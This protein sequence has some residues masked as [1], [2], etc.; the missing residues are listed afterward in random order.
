MRLLWQSIRHIPELCQR[1][2][3]SC[4]LYLCANW[5]FMKFLSKMLCDA[6]HFR[7]QT[8]WF[9]WAFSVS[10]KKKVGQLPPIVATSGAVF[11]AQDRCGCVLSDMTTFREL[12]PQWNRWMFWSRLIKEKFTGHQGSNGTYQTN[13]PS[14]QRMHVHVCTMCWYEN[15]HVQCGSVWDFCSSLCSKMQHCDAIQCSFT[16]RSKI[17]CWTRDGTEGAT[18]FLHVLLQVL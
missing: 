1:P 13:C 6:S 2:P 5:S 14:I 8:T 11:P 18:V 17:L 15:L 4:R 12:A 10:Q 16:S 3:A 7:H 9:S